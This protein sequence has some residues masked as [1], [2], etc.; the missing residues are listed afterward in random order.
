MTWSCRTKTTKRFERHNNVSNEMGS[1]GYSGDWKWPHRIEHKRLLLLGGMRAKLRGCKLFNKTRAIICVV[2][3]IPS[4]DCQ[5]NH[6]FK[7]LWYDKF[8]M[9]SFTRQHKR[10]TDCKEPCIGMEQFDWSRKQF[11]SMLQ[12]VIFAEIYHMP[13]PL[14]LWL[15]NF[16]SFSSDSD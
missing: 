4:L 13:G 5:E 8:S 9:Q 16:G 7:D 2:D 14:Q 1:K 6:I 12:I 15:S 10:E 11:C 3:R